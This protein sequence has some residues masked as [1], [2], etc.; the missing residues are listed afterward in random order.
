MRDSPLY[1]MSDI[2]FL[3]E[4]HQKRRRNR[5]KEIILWYFLFWLPIFYIIIDA[6]IT[7]SFKFIYL[8]DKYA[9]AVCLCL[10]FIIFPLLFDFIFMKLPFEIFRDKITMSEVDSSIDMLEDIDFIDRQIKESTQIAERIYSN[11]R[12]Y[13][14]IGC[15][16][17]IAGV[18]MFYA[19]FWQASTTQ[20]EDL[21]LRL[22]D[23]LPRFGALFFIEYIALFFLK[24]YRIL[25]ENYRYYEAIK[26]DRQNKKLFLELVEK[27]SANQVVLKTIIEYL[28]EHPVH[29]PRI[30]G[31]HKLKSEKALYDDMNFITKITELI[32][33]IKT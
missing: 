12:A 5:K 20:S 30:T 7:G 10:L 32:K 9:I 23:F 33:S 31:D 6:W 15:L 21:S 22:F 27:H 2:D 3:V 24:Q 28:N 17:S 18:V 25:L 19:P 13:L 11:S 14:M 29:I 8:I 26:R 16:I 1:N 4:A